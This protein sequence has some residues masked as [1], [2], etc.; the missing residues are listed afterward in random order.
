MSPRW[1]C[2]HLAGM[3]LA[4]SFLET[5][6]KLAASGITLR[7]GLGIG[8]L[9]FGAL[10]VAELESVATLV[11]LVLRRSTASRTAQIIAASLPSPS[12]RVIPQPSHHPRRSEAEPQ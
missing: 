8:P 5:P 9:V 7:L 4:T 11:V 3:V 12:R 2:V 6:L 1:G 10:S